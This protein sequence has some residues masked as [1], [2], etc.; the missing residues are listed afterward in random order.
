MRYEYLIPFYCTLLVG[1]IK[2]N[3]RASIFAIDSKRTLLWKMLSSKIVKTRRQSRVFPKAN[4]LSAVKKTT[5]GQPTKPCE[6]DCKVLLNLVQEF[7]QETTFHGVNLMLAP[8]TGRFGSTITFF[9]AFSLLVFVCIFLASRFSK[10]QFKTVVEDTH[11]PLIK[12]NFPEVT[13]CNKN[14]LNWLRLE[15][16]KDI[17]LQSKHRNNSYEELFTKI[18]ALYDTF[19]FGTF[20]RFAE[21][22]QYPLNDLNYI[23]FTRVAQ[24]MAWRCWEMLTKCEWL[25]HKED[26]CDIFVERR[27]QLGICLAFNSINPPKAR[28]NDSTWPWR[29]NKGGLD[30]GLKVKVMLNKH[31][32]LTRTMNGIMVMTV[33]PN[34]WYYLPSDIFEQTTSD[35]ILDAFFNRYDDETRRVPSDIRGCV[36][37]D[38]Q[39]SDDFKTLFGHSYRFEN[40]QAQCQQEYLMKY[41]N[42]TLDIFYPPSPYRACQLVDMP[43]LA[44]YNN[45][46]VNF[47]I[48]GQEKYLSSQYPGVVYNC[49]MS[50]DS[51]RYF[52][53]IIS[54]QLT[55]AQSMENTS[56]IN[57]SVYFKSDF[58]T[59]YKTILVFTWVDLIVSFGGTTGLFL[60]CSLISL[61][62]L[63]YFFFVVVPSR[64]RKEHDKPQQ[65]KRRPSRLQKSKIKLR[66]YREAYK[67]QQKFYN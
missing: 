13:I 19:T 52:I 65:L 61:V 34:A 40:C 50:C 1:V 43:C 46:L 38:E 30:S 44:K 45:Y 48:P 29:T 36:F 31:Q 57:L 21:L 10:G 47:E 41:C 56:L 28:V 37:K 54:R 27:S 8:G 24:Y 62:E 35:I 18:V 51:L 6:K 14:R 4:S 64:L 67:R 3:V 53:K 17:F 66:E 33:E 15:E 59:K 55:A 12:V 20:D 7:G 2:K 58:I 9:V 39:N 5:Y 25:N 22:E 60:G 11:F 49:H 23:N 63:I 16:A 42:C 26:C 32:S